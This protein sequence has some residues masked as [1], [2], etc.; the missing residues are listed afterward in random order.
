[1]HNTVVKT[2]AATGAVGLRIGLGFVPSF[3][4]ILNTVSGKSVE[5]VN[6]SLIYSQRQITAGLVTVDI[7]DGEYIGTDGTLKTDDKLKRTVAGRLGYVEKDVNGNTLPEG[8]ILD[9]I[10]DINDT[11]DELLLVTAWRQEV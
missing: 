3:C 7:E 9:D 11:A 10:T 6:P 8:I 1:M 5:Y 4:R 2:I